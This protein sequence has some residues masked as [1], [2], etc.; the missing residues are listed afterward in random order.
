M[1]KIILNQRD[2][3]KGKLNKTDFENAYEAIHPEGNPKKYADH[4]FA[5]FDADS[6]GYIDF[7]EFLLALSALSDRD[8]SKRLHL[9]F[10][11]YD[12]NKN[13]QIDA[14][15]LAEILDALLDLKGVPKTGAMSVQS[16]VD[17]V[18]KSI[19]K[20]KN[21]TLSEEEFVDGCLG[22]TTIMNLLLPPAQD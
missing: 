21:G 20:D 10:K 17:T 5:V 22:N 7:T 9:T 13:G 11:I 6:N 19:D 18:L 4:V 12:K 2:Y 8:Q 1:L 3:P 14:K 15:E 16:L